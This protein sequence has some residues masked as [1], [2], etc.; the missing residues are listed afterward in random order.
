VAFCF[1]CFSEK[2]LNIAHQRI[3]M[4]KN[5]VSL[6]GLVLAL[7]L[8]PLT[9]TVSG[10]LEDEGNPAGDRELPD[11]ASGTGEK[12]NDCGGSNEVKIPFEDFGTKT[13]ELTG[14]I[15]NKESENHKEQNQEWADNAADCSEGD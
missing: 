9:Q 13:G 12:D 4:G 8:A 10:S 14:I 6:I 7:A 11:K 5:S 2:F 1:Y 15:V 3:K